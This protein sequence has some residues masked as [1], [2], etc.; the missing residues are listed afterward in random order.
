VLVQRESEKNLVSALLGLVNWSG[1]VGLVGL[2][3]LDKD[4]TGWIGLVWTVGLFG[5]DWLV[6]IGLDW[7]GR[8]ICEL[9]TVR[10]DGIGLD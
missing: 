3:G 5:Q 6:R 1:L 8:K 7:F 10:M 9:M 2:V 4:W